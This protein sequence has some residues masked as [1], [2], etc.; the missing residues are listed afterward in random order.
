MNTDTQ[1]HVLKGGRAKTLI[2]T[3][4]LSGRGQSGNISELYILKPSVAPTGSTIS[5]WILTSHFDS[6]VMIV[7]GGA[8][9]FE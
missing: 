7:C 3:Y 6:S 9:G 5:D 8:L 1:L 4:T 2:L